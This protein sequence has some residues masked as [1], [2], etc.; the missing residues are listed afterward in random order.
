MAEGSS[1]TFE[2]IA[3][4]F[5]RKVAWGRDAQQAGIQFS[6]IRGFLSS[7]LWYYAVHTFIG[8]IVQG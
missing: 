1:A 6:R 7:P 4:H 3:R 8:D 2:E 5:I